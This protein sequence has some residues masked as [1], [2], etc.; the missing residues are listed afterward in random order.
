MKKIYL[1]AVVCL[2]LLAVALPGMAQQFF[3]N[4][5]E[6]SIQL[7]PAVN[8]RVIQPLKAR[9]LSMDLNAMKHFLE[10]L[11]SEKNVNRLQAPILELPM[12]DGSTGRFRV[13]ESSV[14]EPGLMAKFPEIRTYAGQGIDDPYATIR[15]DFNPYFGFH[16][17][18]LSA[19]TGRIYIDPYARGNTTNYISYFHKDNRPSSFFVCETE[20]SKPPVPTTSNIVTAG[21]CRG[22]ELYT[23][24]LAMACTGEY[25]TAVCAPAAPT[26]PATLAAMATCVNRVTGV[27]ETEVSLR[28]VLIANNDL[29]V[30]LDGTTDPYTNNN[31]STMLG[32][33]QT[34]VDAIIGSANY[35]IGHVVSTG[36]GGVAQLRVPCTGSKARGVTG[37][38]NPVG[39]G[40]YIDYVAHEMGHQWGGNHTFNSITS[41]CAPPNRNGSTA[42]EVGSGTTIQAYAGICG[43]DNTQPNSDPFFHAISFD[44][45]SNYISTGNGFSCKEATSTG[46]T[47]PQITSMSNNG[48]TIPINTPFTLTGTATD[49]NGD[50]LTYCWEEWD[51][52]AG[53]AWNSGATSTT[54]P[55]FKSRIPKTTGSRTFPDIAVILAGYPANPAATMGGLKG[56]TLP[57]VARAMKFRLTVRDNKAGGGGVTSGGEGCQAGQTATFQ[58]NVSGTTPFAVTLPNGGET[59]GTGSTQTVTW[60]PAGTAAAPFSVAN[61]RITLSTDGGTTYP[62]EL[63][64]S[65]AND[66]T[67]TITVPGTPSTTC[68]I[69]V[70]ALGNV[71]FDI[72][73]ANF[74]ISGAATP[75]FNFTTPAPVTVPCGTA[76]AV[77][78]LATTASGGFS[79]PIN[80]AATG[81]PA[82]TTVSF[83]PNPVAPGSSSNVTLNNM[84]TLAAGTYNI[85]VTGTAGAEVKTVTLQ[86][87]VSGGSGPAITAQPANTSACPGS[88][89]SFSVTAT[90]ATGYQWQVSTNGGG[91]WTNV[92]SGGNAATYTVTGVTTAMNNYQ[93][94]VIVTGACG[95][96][97]SNAATLTVNTVPAITANPSAASVCATFNTSFSASSSGT[98]VTNQ[99]QVS[100]DNGTSWTNVS[101][102]GVYSGATTTTLNITG[103]T[104]AM[105]GYCYRMVASGTCTPAANSNSACLTVIVPATVTNHPANASICSGGTITFTAA[106]TNTTVY[107]WQESTDGGATWT[108][109]TNTAPYSGVNTAT[110]T[111]TNVP[112]SFATPVRR[113][114]ALLSNANCTVDIP[115]NAATLTITPKPSAVL[116]ASPSNAIYFP[117]TTT[118]SAAITNGNANT[119]ITWYYNG[120]VLPGVT[121]TS[122]VVDV[123]HLGIYQVKVSDPTGTCFSFSNEDTVVAAPNGRMFITPNPN[124]GIFEVRFFSGAHNFGFNRMVTIYD[125]KGARIYSQPLVVN[126]PYSALK[127]DISKRGKGIYFLVL[128]DYKGGVLAQGK[129]IVQ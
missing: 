74:T 39:D 52:G 2:L 101:N 37:L 123:D 26:V 12:P 45:I 115:T 78:S 86:Y 19:T 83:S 60:D 103:A 129:V 117:Q 9:T 100:T 44:E 17:Q 67:E 72:S 77:I 36:G 69:R 92:P 80:L 8:K 116:S 65:T 25:A 51:L 114:R 23:Y 75:T 85:S 121:G 88:N 104:A 111:I 71:F 62:T 68:R 97:T 109:L 105:N 96:A 13:W 91:T 70:E 14:M 128:G 28:M 73:N 55:L 48:A 56:E 122:Y 40:F 90:S 120:A 7:N 35:D 124:R 110:L 84:S 22:T 5:S 54:A 11:P 63:L 94:H 41:N 79:T 47:I 32:Q 42:Y 1:P 31:G 46:N 43:A 33:N 57:T 53:G 24:R 107:K 20:D 87:I 108:T 126:G 76:S 29:L 27:Y 3:A 50:A 34:N 21:P 113:Y 16:A 38:P 95:S 58:I 127:V 112:A 61:V 81:N 59:W 118:L 30:Y 64:A 102:G 125:S 99:W 119:V 4:V 106:G 15:F 98:G 6:N 89:A 66:G 49:G 10:S 18:V 82:P 93:Y